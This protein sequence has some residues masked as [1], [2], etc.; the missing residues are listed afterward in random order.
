MGIRVVPIGSEPK[1]EK[2][3]KG[4]KDTRAWVIEQLEKEGV[5]ANL[6]A[7]TGALMDVLEQTRATERGDVETGKQYAYGGGV[8]KTKLYDY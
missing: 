5:T 8:R 3:Q 2:K 4:V 6:N 7:S 1:K